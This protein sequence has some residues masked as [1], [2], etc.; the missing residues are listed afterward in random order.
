MDKKK[1]ILLISSFILI[2]CILFALAKKNTNAT[3]KI[4]PTAVIAAKQ[5]PSLPKTTALKQNEKSLQDIVKESLIFCSELNELITPETKIKSKERFA[6]NLHFKK[7]GRVHRLRQFLEDGD[8][9]SYEKL[10]YFI[11]DEDGFPEITEL[12]EDQSITELLKDADIIYESEDINYLLTNKKELAISFENGK[13]I[14]ITSESFEC[15][16]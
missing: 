1:I 13:I 9:G 3:S 6:H 4:S 12:P 15:N 11:E 7:G 5:L 14:K 2:T 8:E 16:P 10:V